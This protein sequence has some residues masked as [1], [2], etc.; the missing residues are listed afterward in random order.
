MVRAPAKG[1]RP[2]VSPLSAEDQRAC[3]HSGAGADEGVVDVGGLV[4]G[5]TPDLAHSLGDAVHSVDVC[6]AELSS[7]CIQRSRRV[8]LAEAVGQQI[9]G[10]AGTAEAE[11][12][13]LS[14]NERGEVVV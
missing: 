8:H 7:V 12:L 1:P 5:T 13:E 2:R 9:G 14:E 6:L 4:G 10:F 11:L 3:R